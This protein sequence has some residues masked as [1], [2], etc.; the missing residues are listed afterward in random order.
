MYL[1]LTF[2]VIL[3]R[4]FF[5]II[6]K[7]SQVSVGCFCL[8]FL[9]IRLAC[10]Y[11][12]F[13]SSHFVSSILWV[14]CVFKLNFVHH[15]VYT[16]CYRY[17]MTRSELTGSIHGSIK[18]ITSLRA[19]SAEKAQRKKRGNAWSILFSVVLCWLQC[20]DGSFSNNFFF[21]HC[22]LLI[23]WKVHA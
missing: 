8:I 6:P 9:S 16:I 13:L 11:F 2:P 14:N 5:V 17:Q 15:T 3:F 18:K 12:L 10:Y 22:Y 23:A 1:H 21:G 4:N 7:Y 19:K 20:W